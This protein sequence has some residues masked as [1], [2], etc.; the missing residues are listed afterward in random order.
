MRKLLDRTYDASLFVAGVF[1]VGIFAVMIGEAVLRKMGSYITGAS[2]L[3][4]WFCAAAG[5]LAM[6]ATFKRGDMVRVGLL[7]DRLSDRVRKPV[8]LACLLLAFVFTAFMLWAVAVYLWDGWRVGEMTQG[9]IEIAVWIPKLSFLV[10]VFLLLVA[11][12]DELLFA[13][14]SPASGLHAEKPLSVEDPTNL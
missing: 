14:R 2:E 6:A 1:L 11:V 3:V 10:G 9:M 7:V 4:G 8:L 12:I 5:F 13:L